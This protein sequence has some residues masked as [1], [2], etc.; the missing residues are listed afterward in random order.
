MKKKLIK[1]TISKNKDLISYKEEY[2]KYKDLN[3]KYNTLMNEF[4]ELWKLGYKKI[5]QKKKM[6]NLSKQKKILYLFRRSKKIENRFKRI[7]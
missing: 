5:F 6:K 4:N 7:K 2:Y 1:K 3:K